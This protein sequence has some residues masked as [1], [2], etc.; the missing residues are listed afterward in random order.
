MPATPVYGLAY[1]GPDDLGG[2]L[3]AGLA[4]LAADV[5]AALGQVAPDSGVLTNLGVTPAA[6]WTLT[7]NE[8]RVVGKL[9]HFYFRLERSG[10]NLVANAVGDLPDT[11]VLTITTAAKRPVM[12][13]WAGAYR[14]S[15]TGGAA[16][17]VGSTGVLQITSAHSSSSI[18]TTHVLIAA[19]TYSIA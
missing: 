8:H 12:P 13:Y 17:I 19:G 4:D 18:D 9:L 10:A 11:Q 1:P 15:F 16:L 7:N 5:D 2:G 14:A 3:P 6:G